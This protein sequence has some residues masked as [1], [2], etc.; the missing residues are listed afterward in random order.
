MDGDVGVDL[1]DADVD[2]RVR[3][4]EQLEHPRERIAEGGG[5]RADAQLAG[6]TVGRLPDGG[7]GGRR[8]AD[9]LPA[10]VE[11]DRPGRG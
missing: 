4:L 7:I 11:Q 8:G 3:L 1:L 10:D 6:L 9:E 5:D 2:P